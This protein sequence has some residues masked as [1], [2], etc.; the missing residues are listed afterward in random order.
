MT[1]VLA[2]PVGERDAFARELASDVLRVERPR[3]ARVVDLDVLQAP[4]LEDRRK[5]AANRLDFGELG[6][7]PLADH[8]EQ[9]RPLRR[10]PV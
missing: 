9:Q 10:L 7:R 4:P 5:T 6:H 8:V 3:E 2:A 1:Q